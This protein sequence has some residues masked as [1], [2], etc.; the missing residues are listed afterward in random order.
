[1]RIAVHPKIQQQ[2]MGS[3]FL[4]QIEVLATKQGFDFLGTSFGVNPSLL[5]FWL[6][7]GFSTTRIGFT[8]DKASGEHSAL[9]LKGSND[10]ARQL[11]QALEKDFYRSFDYLLLEEYKTLTT[12]LVHLLLTQQSEENLVALSVQDVANVHAYARGERLYSS[13]AFSL[14][15]WLKHELLANTAPSH[16]NRNIEKNVLILIARLIQKHNSETVCQQYGLTGKKMLNQ[17]MQSYVSLRLN[18]AD[19]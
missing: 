10:E 9:L 19:I 11:Q 5:S 15:L 12:R 2:G 4:A 8:K 16:C 1:M 14:Y 7:A 18:N 13:C 6:K 3:Y 17:I